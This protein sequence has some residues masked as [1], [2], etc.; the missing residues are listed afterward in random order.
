MTPSPLKTAGT[1]IIKLEVF[2]KCGLEN[3]LEGCVE[4]EKKHLEYQNGTQVLKTCSKND[5]DTGAKER[6][7][8]QVLRTCSKNEVRDDILSSRPM[9]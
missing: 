3:V 6:I 7:L 1:P 4:E 5:V 2:Y 9:S 8:T